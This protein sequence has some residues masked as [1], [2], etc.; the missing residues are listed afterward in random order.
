MPTQSHSPMSPCPIYPKVQK[1]ELFS[2]AEPYDSL[3]GSSPNGNRGSGTPRSLRHNSVSARYLSNSDSFQACNRSAD[4]L[5]PSKFLWPRYRKQSRK[6][7]SASSSNLNDSLEDQGY[8]TPPKTSDRKEHETQIERRLL[9][10]SK[11]GPDEHRVGMPT[12]GVRHESAAASES[13]G[14]QRNKLKEGLGLKHHASA[15]NVQPAEQQRISGTPRDNFADAAPF[16]DIDVPLSSREHLE[17]PG[18]PAVGIANQVRGE[19]ITSTLPQKDRRQSCPKG[20]GDLD[21][22]RAQV[23]YATCIGSDTDNSPH[24]EAPIGMSSDLSITLNRAGQGSSRRQSL[25]AR[26]AGPNRHPSSTSTETSSIASST[27]SSSLWKKW[28]SWKLVLVDKTPS[29]QDL[30]NGPQDLSLSSV[31]QIMNKSPEAN[32]DHNFPSP[33]MQ[34]THKT[35]STRNLSDISR[36]EEVE[37]R[38]A[39]LSVEIVPQTRVHQPARNAQE[40]SGAGTSRG[41]IPIKTTVKVPATK[42]QPLALVETLPLDGT[43]PD[44]QATSVLRAGVDDFDQL[45]DSTD[46][47]KGR[48]IKKIQIVVSFDEVADLVIEAHLRGKKPTQ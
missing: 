11:Q 21:R 12:A 42:P 39:R 37:D 25:P 20:Y 18:L 46:S 32:S 16:Q 7:Y 19:H 28:R 47:S 43:L 15:A 31:N 5:D 33:H 38:K 22:P 44:S 14:N 3:I 4:D 27:R 23:T 24:D 34:P 36:A 10:K 29:F 48:K 45:T 1:Y 30:S 9:Q 8:S 17:H 26:L 13:V 2:R 41:G 6:G 35:R 40:V